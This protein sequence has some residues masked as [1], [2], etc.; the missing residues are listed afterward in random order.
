MANMTQAKIGDAVRKIEQLLTASA[1]SRDI[2]DYYTFQR[3]VAPLLDAERGNRDGAV[4]VQAPSHYVAALLLLK[5]YHRKFRAGK[6]GPM[7]LRRYKLL[8]SIFADGGRGDAVARALLADRPED[9]TLETDALSGAELRSRFLGA[10]ADEDFEDANFLL[11]RLDETDHDPGERAYLQARAAYAAGKLERVLRLLDTVPVDAID[12]PRAAWISAKAAA[13]LNDGKALDRVLNEIGDRLSPCAWLHLFELLNP[14][15][16]EARDLFVDRL[17]SGLTISRD[18]PAYE[19]WA[20]LHVQMIGR[21]Y[22]RALEMVEASEATGEELF[23]EDVR[24][25]M[26]SREFLAALAIED[27]ARTVGEPRD[28]AALMFPL[29]EQGHVSAF[30]AA[31][32]MLSMMSDHVAIVK[33]AERYPHAPGLPWHHDL[34][35]VGTVYGST[36]VVGS[37]L[38]DRLG[39]LL[40]RAATNTALEHSA[41]AALAGRLSIMAKMSFLGA[42]AE[43]DRLTETRDIWRDCG[44]AALG[45]FRALEAEFNVRL[46][47]PMVARLDVPALRASLPQGETRLRSTLRK[48]EKAARPGHGLMFGELRT[49]LSEIEDSLTDAAASSVSTAIHAA[50]RQVINRSVTSEQAVEQLGELISADIVGRFRNPPAHAQFLRLSELGGA[51]RHVESALERLT[52]LL[53]TKN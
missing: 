50:F 53:P 18:D 5:K 1:K 6:I 20:T 8:T 49:L 27:K 51:L 25:D 44:L 17:P 38:K 3:A 40:R 23:E 43:Y 10:L 16:I 21:F 41:R 14:K 34:S 24:D 26:A 39:R 33:L 9:R 30:R 36:F 35:I 2:P 46:V 19:E 15:T 7:D 29:I 28:T 13:V 22:R 37:R 52:V 11:G 47:I 45:L 48:L 31:V 12:R 42:A 32:E 4:H